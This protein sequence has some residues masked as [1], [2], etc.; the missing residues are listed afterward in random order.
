MVKSDRGLA[1]KAVMI[2]ARNPV[3]GSVFTEI[4]HDDLVS[5]KIT[6]DGG[7]PY[8]EGICTDG[9]IICVEVLWPSHVEHSQFN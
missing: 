1:H 2:G 5:R 9:S 6:W 8:G 3:W 4:G 7:C